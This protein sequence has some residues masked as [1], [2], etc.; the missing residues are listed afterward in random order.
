MANELYLADASLVHHNKLMEELENPNYI[1][2]NIDS[3]FL[4]YF[5]MLANS[6]DIQ[7]QV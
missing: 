5:L 7:F 4:D 2:K 6:G 3:E 1:K